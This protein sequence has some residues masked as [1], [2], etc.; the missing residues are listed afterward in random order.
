[1]TEL[2]VFD[3]L[4]H[5]TLRIETAGPKGR[6]SGTGFFTNF[7]EQDDGQS[8]PAI[9]TNKHV[10]EGCDTVTFRFTKSTGEGGIP[11]WGKILEFSTTSI[12]GRWIWHDDS[13]VDL[14]AYPIGNVIQKYRDDDVELFI[15][16][17][18]L[19]NDVADVKFL[20]S[21]VSIEDILMIGYPNGLWD[22]QNNL[23]ISRRGV[24]ATPPAID[25]EGQ[26]QFVIDCACFPGSSGS[27]VLLF[28]PT[29]FYD[30]KSG[31]MMMG[32]RIKLIGILWGGPQIDNIGDIKVI[33]VPT[34]SI[35]I[36][37]S[38]IPLNLGYCIKAS[39]LTYFEEAF[40]RAMQL[41]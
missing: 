10:I 8:V 24:T 38:K 5:T 16:S 9:I 36:S 18:S 12:E 13:S 40:G 1:M 25:F 6:G 20:E 14:C 37:H 22:S 21:L 35:V 39:E 26:P 17:F 15:K 27:P 3:Q 7:C 41:K 28:N 23:P 4:V 19:N 29:S 30:K 33:P 11:E 31:N 32:S 34:E 2:N